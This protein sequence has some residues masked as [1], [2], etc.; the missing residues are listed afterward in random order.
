M[1]SKVR[2]SKTEV[3]PPLWLDDASLAVRQKWSSAQYMREQALPTRRDKL[4][5]L[6]YG[7]RVYACSGIHL[8]SCFRRVREISLRAK[9][10]AEI[11]P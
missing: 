1:K 8:S 2:I 11:V 10:E 9:D 5:W 7:R 4:L 3:I 6:H